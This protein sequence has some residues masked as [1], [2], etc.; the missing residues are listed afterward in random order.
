MSQSLNEQAQE[1]NEIISKHNPNVFSLLSD[2]G[3][4]IYFPKK[5]IL[6]QGK[7]AAPPHDLLKEYSV[8]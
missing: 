6:S 1:L 7:E 8:L 2:K 5:G 3:K 4:A